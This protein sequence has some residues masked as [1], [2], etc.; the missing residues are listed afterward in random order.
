MENLCSWML[1][2]KYDV[3]EITICSI[4][5][6]EHVCLLAG[7]LVPNI[8]P[9]NHIRCKSKCVC[10]V[11]TARLADDTNMRREVFFQSRLQHTSEKLTGPIFE[12]A[13]DIEKLELEA[14]GCGLVEDS[15]C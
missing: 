5:E 15:S 14:I 4:I 9:G 2:I 12:A 3:G 1:M 7:E 13:T 6:V 11:V 10:D 8:A